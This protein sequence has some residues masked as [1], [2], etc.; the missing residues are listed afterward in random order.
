M[1]LIVS[2]KKMGVDSKVAQKNIWN[3]MEVFCEVMF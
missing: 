2:E 3:K 1:S